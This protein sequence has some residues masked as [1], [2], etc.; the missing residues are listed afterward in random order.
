MR[1]SYSTVHLYDECPRWFYLAKIKKIKVEQDEKYMRRGNLV[2]TCLE[3]FYGKE[4]TDINIL[5]EHFETGWESYG[6]H[7]MMP[8]QKEPT[9]GM[10]LNGITR[11]LNVTDVEHKFRF[12]DPDYIGYADIVNKE[13]HIIGDWKTSTWRGEESEVAYKE[14][15]KYY[16]W[17]YE[18]EFG[19]IPL[20]VVHFLKDSKSVHYQFMKKELDN[21]DK[22]LKLFSEYVD[23]YKEAKDYKKNFT[24]SKDCPMFCPYK[25]ICFNAKN[26]I[27]F[28]LL[29]N[30]PYIRI[31]NNISE[32]LKK[33]L[34]KKFSYEKQNAYWIRENSNWDAIVRLYNERT[35]T[36]GIGFKN[37]LIK[38]LKAYCEYKK[39][40]FVLEI[41]DKTKDRIEKDIFP[42]K[43]INIDL[44]VEQIEASDVA[45]KENALRVKLPTGV[46]KTIMGAEFIRRHKLKTLFVVD[47]LDLLHQTRKELKKVLGI[48]IGIIGGGEFVE[49]WI[50]VA[51]YHSLRTKCNKDFFERQQCLIVDEIQIGSSKT[52]LDISKKCK[53]AHYRLGLS[54]TPKHRADDMLIESQFGKI[55][56][57]LE[58][59]TAQEK[60]YLVPG[61][62]IFFHSPLVSMEKDW[63]DDYN[64]NIVNN[65]ER[66]NI[67]FDYVSKKIKKQESCLIL[68]KSVEHGV[69]LNNA[70]SN[71]FHIHGK[72]D[73]KIREEMWD[74]LRDK[75]TLVVIATLKI[76]SK[77]LNIKSLNNIVNAAANGNGDDSI[78]VLGRSLRL[79]FNKTEG[80]Y[81]DFIDK[82]KHSKKWSSTRLNTLKN[83]G[84]DIEVVNNV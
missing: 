84:Y 13:N 78:Q 65:K 68:T 29:I 30:G 82:G 27:K 81:I 4:I 6:L 52:I 9:W 72:V 11:K 21:L 80:V 7:N 10:V 69:F 23:K 66:N 36:L 1:L 16:A 48:E 28:T 22:K 2:H 59:K 46:G 15:M 55:E 47:T 54:A 51:T 8:T 44:R 60:G 74:N 61:K 18:K 34:N 73:K 32:I 76:A 64:I 38:V 57:I 67:I 40:E 42:D 41:I 31:E 53:N 49:E 79:Y 19:E 25:E 71:S 58:S 24:A 45:E 50:T 12:K 75:K 33:M 39:K 43:L 77:G 17:A 35:Q 37:R 70:I 20:T 26:T 83:E 62:I 63:R 3:K 14:Q 5:K 56:Y